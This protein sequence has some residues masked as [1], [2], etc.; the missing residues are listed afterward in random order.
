LIS[1]T[2]LGI[3]GIAANLIL[4][5]GLMMS[6]QPTWWSRADLGHSYLGVMLSEFGTALLLS[7]I[8]KK[9]ILSGIRSK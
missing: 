6:M 8:M 4:A 9:I 7:L 5:P 2:N 1:C 3:L